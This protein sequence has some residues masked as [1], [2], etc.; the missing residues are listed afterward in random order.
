MKLEDKYYDEVPTGKVVV[1]ASWGTNISH[2][3]EIYRNM[4]SGSL[5]TPKY[6]K[7]LKIQDHD[8]NFKSI[9]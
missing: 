4:K 8:K 1:L 5:D 2:V 9:N 3:S 7:S 6:G